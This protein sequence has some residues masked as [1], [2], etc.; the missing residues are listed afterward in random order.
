MRSPFILAGM[1]T[2]IVGYA[3]NI[4]NASLGT[5][6]FGIYLCVMGLYGA[7][8]GVLAWCAF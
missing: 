2:G 1:F 3:I 5:K 6:Y 4:S 8:P 7:L